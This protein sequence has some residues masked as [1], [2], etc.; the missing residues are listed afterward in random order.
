M[1]DTN[2]V[3]D[4]HIEDRIRDAFKE[5]PSKRFL[6]GETIASELKDHQ[7]VFYITKGYVKVVG[8]TSSGQQQIHFIYGPEQIFPVRVVFGDKLANFYYVGLTDT[9]VISMD[10]SEFLKKLEEDSSLAIAVLCQQQKI[11]GNYIFNLRLETS[12]QRVIHRLLVLSSHFGTTKKDTATINFPLTQQE[13]A[14]T[15]NLSRET[16]SK[17]LNE[18]E[19]KEYIVWGRRNI[20]VYPKKLRTLFNA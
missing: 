10:R 9:E 17:L 15:I 1:Q 7:S 20:F 16:T 19:Q 2:R 4:S 8:N 6:K 12:Q 13:F 18:L 11:F 5:A 3:L 14:D